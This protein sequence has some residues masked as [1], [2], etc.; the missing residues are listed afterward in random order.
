M[1]DKLGQLRR[2]ISE[3]PGAPEFVEL[4]QLLLKSQD[5]R[6]EARDVCFKGLA[7]DPK[8]LRARL[9]LARL[10]YLD[11]LT[12]FCIRELLEIQKNS[13]PP[14]L[15]RLL[16]MLGQKVG[17]YLG[18]YS[19]TENL[20]STTAPD[21]SLQASKPEVVAEIDI[22]AEFLEALEDLDADS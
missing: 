19:Q 13:S 17:S 11:G 5:T 18:G 1:V 2:I 20:S 7:E 8:N 22:E 9:V 3:R 6:P 12:E 10:F 16:E 4:A 21:S 14:S 15:E